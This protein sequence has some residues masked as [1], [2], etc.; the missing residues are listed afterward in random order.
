MIWKELAW[1]KAKNTSEINKRMKVVAIEVVSKDFIY[2]LNA[3]FRASI[4]LPSP[5]AAIPTQIKKISLLKNTFWTYKS[6]V[7][8]RS[9]AITETK[10][11]KIDIKTFVLIQIIIFSK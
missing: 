8:K 6:A 3:P 7:K 5:S 10:S 1:K 2:P 11:V 4:E 9:L